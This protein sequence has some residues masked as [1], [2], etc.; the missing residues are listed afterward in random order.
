M[1]NR[2]SRVT[3]CLLVAALPPWPR[4]RLRRADT[5]SSRR[6]PGPSTTSRAPL[7]WLLTNVPR[8]RRRARSFESSASRIRRSASCS[9]LATHWSSAAAR[10]PASAGSAFLRAAPRAAGD[11]R[12]AKHPSTCTQSGWVQI[13]GVDTRSPRR[14]SCTPAKASARRLP[15][16]VHCPD[17]RRPSA[18]RHDAPIR[19]HGTH[20]DR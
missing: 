9:D 3:L 16:A 6:R 2:I 12:R 5:Q 10:T 18:A 13:L 7:R 17:D 14:Q 20:R 11:R 8:T 1:R 4:R 19:E 15:G